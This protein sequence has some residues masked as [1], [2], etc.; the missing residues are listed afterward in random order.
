MKE[1][2]NLIGQWVDACEVAPFSQVAPMT[3][4][5][6]IVRFVRSAVL[7][8]NN[9]L[10]VVRHRTVVLAQLAILTPISGPPPHEIA[11]LRGGH[12]PSFDVSLRCA[13]SLRIAMK[14]AALISAS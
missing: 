1:L 7:F 5:R 10:D 4:Q 3:G 13:F 8:R 6:E 2:H 9:V 14:S 12:G 11:R